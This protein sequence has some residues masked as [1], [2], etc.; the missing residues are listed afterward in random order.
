MEKKKIDWEEER[1]NAVKM[2]LIMNIYLDRALNYVERMN[3]FTAIVEK[4]PTEKEKKTMEFDT[5]SMK[6]QLQNSINTWLA[7]FDNVLK[8]GKNLPVD[9]IGRL[10]E[11]AKCMRE[12]ESEK[13][14]K[15]EGL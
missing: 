15:K 6:T 9:L 14:S 1:D 4:L 7:T 8:E 13:E 10:A 2:G 11:I 12:K 3:P 5:S